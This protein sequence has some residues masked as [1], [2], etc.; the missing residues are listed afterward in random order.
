M[1]GKNGMKELGGAADKGVGNGWGGMGMQICVNGL[2]KL[3][4][5]P[6]WTNYQDDFRMSG[7]LFIKVNSSNLLR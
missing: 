5:F 4:I 3:G 6:K 1:V 2:E 7:L